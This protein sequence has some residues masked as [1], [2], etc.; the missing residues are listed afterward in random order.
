VT[1]KDKFV[2]LWLDTA[3]CIGHRRWVRSNHY[4]FHV[5]ISVWFWASIVIEDFVIIILVFRVVSS[6]S[7]IHAIKMFSQMIAQLCD[8]SPGVNTKCRTLS[9]IELLGHSVIEK[10]MQ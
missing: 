6:I 7:L 3:S 4:R 9:R 10:S 5:N 8:S 2:G 1:I